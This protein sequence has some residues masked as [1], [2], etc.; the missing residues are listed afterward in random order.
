MSP[1]KRVRKAVIPAAGFGTRFLPATKAM[2]KE[3]LPIVDKPVIQYV[4]EDA[5]SAG[6][7][8]ILIVTGFTKR[9][10]EDHFDYSFELESRLEE[11]GKLKQLAEVRAIANLANFHYLRQKGPLGNAT[12]IWNAKD[13]IGDEPFLVLFGDDFFDATPSRSQQLIDAYEKEGGSA[14]LSCIRTTKDEDYKRY[15]FVTGHEK[16]LGLIEVESIIEKPGPGVITSDY[17]VISGYLYEPSIFDAIEQSMKNLEVEKSN[18]ELVYTD[19]LNILLKGG[20]SI[21]ALEIENGTYHDC[22]N[23]LDYLKTV[24]EFGLKHPDLNGEFKKFL[25]DLTF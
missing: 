18:R 20:H 19:A 15:G 17:A 6:I 24:V 13:F 5:I 16:R 11:A 3:M 2:P 25:Q 7:E 10:I 9:S 14:I 23:K 1:K 22:G 12:P 21:Y 4:V 8:D